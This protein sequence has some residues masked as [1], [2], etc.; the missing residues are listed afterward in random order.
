MI[1]KTNQ[2]YLYSNTTL[3]KVNL[4]ILCILLCF[5]CIQIQLLL[6]LIPSKSKYTESLRRIQIQLLLRLILKMVWE[7][8]RGLVIQIQLLLRLIGNLQYVPEPLPH[9]QIQLLL[10]LIAVIQTI[11]CWSRWGHSNTTLVKVNPTFIT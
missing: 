7:L 9:I 10:R 6:R 3:V 2:K 1:G 11:R 5:I 8:V 4:I